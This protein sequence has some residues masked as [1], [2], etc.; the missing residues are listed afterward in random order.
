MTD[1]TGSGA[2]PSLED[3]IPEAL[4]DCEQVAQWLG[5]KESWV[6]YA[7]KNGIIPCIKVG[8]YVRFRRPDI[9]KWIDDGGNAGG[10]EAVS[11]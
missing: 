4:L 3:F 6:F 1:K 9:Q 7:A 5:V 11:E 8:R 2:G 10:E